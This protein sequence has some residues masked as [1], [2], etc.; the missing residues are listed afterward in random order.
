MTLRIVT[1]NV[2]CRSAGHEQ[3][4]YL[5]SFH[6]DI[7]FLQECHSPEHYPIPLEKREAFAAWSQTH[8]VRIPRGIMIYSDSVEL[9][10]PKTLRNFLSYVLAREIEIHGKEILLVNIYGKFHV[11]ADVTVTMDKTFDEL[12]SLLTSYSSVILGG[13]LN[14]SVDYGRKHRGRDETVLRCIQTDFNLM[15]CTKGVGEKEIITQ[16]SKNKPYQ[17]DYIFATPELATNVDCRVVLNDKGL[18][19]HYPVVAEFAGT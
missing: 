8:E 15:D 6:P 4:E 11:N 7:A 12:S 1:W 3:W 2:N 5:S 17:V 14:L 9:K 10:V 18:S 13:D 19:D 16:E